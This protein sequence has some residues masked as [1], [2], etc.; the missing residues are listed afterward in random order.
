MIVA[1]RKQRALS[2][3]G[4]RGPCVAAACSP[5]W[6]AVMPLAGDDLVPVYQAQ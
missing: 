1:W 4:G 2:A 6:E 3:D 5:F